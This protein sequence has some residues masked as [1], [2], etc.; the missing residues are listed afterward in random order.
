MF[1]PITPPPSD[2]HGF[3]LGLSTEFGDNA[4]TVAEKVNAGFKHVYGMLKGM[5]ASLADE[6]EYVAKSEF[7]AACHE[8]E[9]LRAELANVKMM[10]QGLGFAGT[11]KPI[12]ATTEPVLRVIASEAPAVVA[13]HA[14][15][16][17]VVTVTEKTEQ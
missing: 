6:V 11:S 10:V 7:D 15:N 9:E 1:I 14:A 3:A 17:P 13:K 5:G 4:K 8:I 16:E 2:H 12:G